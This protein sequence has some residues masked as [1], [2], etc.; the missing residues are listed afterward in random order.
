MA[1]AGPNAVVARCPAAGT[2]QRRPAAQGECTY[3]SYLPPLS[4]LRAWCEGAPRGKRVSAFAGS[5]RGLHD[6]IQDLH[7]WIHS[8]P[9]RI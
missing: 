4:L 1:W 2:L 7:G 6:Q 9:Y 3:L 8:F 5:I